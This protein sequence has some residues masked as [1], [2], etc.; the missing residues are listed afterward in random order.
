M[1]TEIIDDIKVS[2]I[3][4]SSESGLNLSNYDAR[5][6]HTGAGTFTLTSTSLLDNAISIYLPNGGLDVDVEKTIDFKA[7]DTTENSITLQALLPV[8]LV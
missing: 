1:A 6:K 4:I 3:E 5:L 8:V 7:L 2:T